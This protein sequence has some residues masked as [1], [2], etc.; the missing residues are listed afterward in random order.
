M[1]DEP[2]LRPTSTRHGDSSFSGSANDNHS[3]LGVNP[4]GANSLSTTLGYGLRKRD[5][6]HFG[7]KAAVSKF[8]GGFAASR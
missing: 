8:C 4:I 1:F 3:H 6:G 2:L 5:D 7:S